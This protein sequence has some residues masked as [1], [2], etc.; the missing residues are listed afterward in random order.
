MGFAAAWPCALALA[1]FS[2]LFLAVAW[3]R[4]VQADAPAGIFRIIPP[5]RG[6][7]T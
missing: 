6:A 7:D 3:W 5:A 2:A 1:G 4:L